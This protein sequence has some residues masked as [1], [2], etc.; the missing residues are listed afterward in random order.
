MTYPFSIQAVNPRPVAFPSQLWSPF[1]G[2]TA[3]LCKQRF[4]DESGY[5]G[6]IVAGSGCKSNACDVNL[7]SLNRV[8]DQ[9]HLVIH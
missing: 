6:S 7:R 5:F 8:L 3:L 1:I 9:M 4:G 2:T